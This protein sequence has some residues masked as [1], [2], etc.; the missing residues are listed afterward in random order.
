MRAIAIASIV[1]LGLAAAAAQAEPVKITPSADPGVNVRYEQSQ[2]QRTT[3]G[4]QSVEVNSRLLFA[5][6]LREAEGAPGAA[7][8][9]TVER[10]AVDLAQPGGQRA[11]YDSGNPQEG[12]AQN[13]L[14]AALAPTVGSEATMRITPEGDAEDVALSQQVAANQAASLAGLAPQSLDEAVTRVFVTPDAPDEVEQGDRWTWV[15]K[16]PL[17]EGAS[18]NIAHDMLVESIE[19][20]TVTITFTGNA[21]LDFDAPAQEGDDPRPEL[22]GSEVSGRMVWDAQRGLAVSWDYLS[23]LTILT[24]MPQNPGQKSPVQIESAMRLQRQDG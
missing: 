23:S 1:T 15:R 18:L 4:M 24:P 10:V 20:D 21:T 5:L 7:A 22:E 17:D 11:F 13:P 12:D 3:L 14:A 9:L 8:T 6:A 16:Q 19:G 2:S